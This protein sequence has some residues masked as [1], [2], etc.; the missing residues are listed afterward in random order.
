MQKFTSIRNGIL[1]GNITIQGKLDIGKP[2]VSSGLDIGEGGSYNEGVI[3]YAYNSLNPSGSRFTQL[4]DLN[5]SNTLSGMAGDRLYFG[6]TNLFWA[7]RLKLSIAKSSEKIILKYWNG[8]L[9]QI[10]YMGILKNSSKSIGENIMEQITT[11]EYCTWDRHANNDWI[12]SDNQLDLIPNTG[13]QLYWICYEIPPEGLIQA[14][15]IT[16][17]KIR[18]SDLD[19]I[20]G[21]AFS[22]YWGNARVGMC[23]MIYLARSKGNI[24]NDKNNIAITNTQQN[25]TLILDNT[26]KFATF[27]WTLPYGIDTSC[28]LDF[29]LNF[30]A[31]SSISSTNIELN[32]KKIKNGTLIGLDEMSDL[33]NTTNIAILSGNTVNIGKSLTGGTYLN[34]Q[35]ISPMDIIS[36]Q[37]S[38]LDS[39][40][41]KFYLLGLVVHYIMWTSGGHIV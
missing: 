30:S 40:N 29:T 7:V 12:S 14:P 3:S 31:E 17:I 6:H 22:V 4:I 37:I 21:L 20:S 18:G 2:G 24:G 41:V 36:V 38:R 26:D 23:D 16:G 27:M 32:I 25:T 34:I 28:A 8:A 13:N 15:T 9:S 19:I 5:T 35:D 10:S 39:D 11:E 33:V 1:L